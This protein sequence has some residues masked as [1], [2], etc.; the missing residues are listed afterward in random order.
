MKNK[1]ELEEK[2]GGRKAMYTRGA[3]YTMYGK[4]GNVYKATE[5][6]EHTVGPGF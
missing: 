6:R 5:T 1:K 2:I 4:E 3:M